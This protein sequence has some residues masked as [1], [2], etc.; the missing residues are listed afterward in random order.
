MYK[1]M[2]AVYEKSGDG[3]WDHRHAQSGGLVSAR[4]GTS[5]ARHPVGPVVPVSVNKSA[6]ITIVTSHTDIIVFIISVL[7]R[8]LSTNAIPLVYASSSVWI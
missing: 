2:A 4:A 1:E 7:S 5:P 8:T 6:C 3:D